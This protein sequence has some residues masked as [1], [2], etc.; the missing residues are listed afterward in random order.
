MEFARR[1]VL[2]CMFFS[3]GGFRPLANLTKISGGVSACWRWRR[4]IQTLHAVRDIE[5]KRIISIS[6]SY[7]ACLTTQQVNAGAGIQIQ[8]IGTSFRGGCISKE[9]EPRPPIP[10]TALPGLP[11][12]L[13][14]L[15][16]IP[17][18]GKTKCVTLSEP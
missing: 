18:L 9:K 7:V 10:P 2:F 1:A 12:V 16:P 17:V 5:G 4:R 15:I 3:T 14:P 8:G 13:L 11:R 6:R